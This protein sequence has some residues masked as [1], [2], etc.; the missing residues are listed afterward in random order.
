MRGVLHSATF[1][2][3]PLTQL[4][5]A[6]RDRHFMGAALTGKFLLAPLA[7]W[8][9]PAFLPDAPAIGLGRECDFGSV[10]ARGIVVMF[11]GPS[12]NKLGTGF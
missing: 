6:F 8:R 10:F 7:V 1:A 2:Q 4:P 9:L 5:D 3:V 11:G 12:R